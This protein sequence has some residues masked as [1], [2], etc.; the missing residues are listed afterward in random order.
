MSIIAHEEN[1]KG[2]TLSR[3]FIDALQLF[4]KS[5]NAQA[6]KP[7]IYWPHESGKKR[8][9]LEWAVALLKDAAT[10]PPDSYVPIMPVDELSIACIERVEGNVSNIPVRR[11]HLGTID[12][13]F[14]DA[15]LDTDLAMYV[16]SVRR[17][18]EDRRWGVAVI[19]RMA[20][21]YKAEYVSKSVR[22]RGN[23]LRPVQLACQNVVIGLAA[24]R[25]DPTFDGLRVPVYLTCE[26]PHVATHEANRA[27]AA[28]IL[29]DAFQNGGTMEIRFGDHR[30]P[31]HIP[32]GLARF[33][34][35]V[36]VPL[37]SDDPKCITP[38]E[39]RKLFTAVTLMPDDLR[40]RLDGLIDRGVIS[41][42]RACYVLMAGVWTAIE[43][44]YV[45]ATSARIDSITRG[46][47]P[48]D[49]RGA[50]Q[51]ELETCR[52]A[53]ML[54]TLHRYLA[55][56]DSAGADGVRVFEDQSANV[57]WNVNDDH[58]AVG[59]V[60]ERP[61]TVPWQ[62]IEHQSAADTRV[63]RMICVP[64]GL[65]TTIDFA[66][67]HSL[68]ERFPDTAIALLVPADMATLVPSSIPTMLC[69]E[70]LGE[71]DTGIERRLA[72]LRVGR[73]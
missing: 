71:L 40:L 34:R 72:T 20:R 35:T 65:P 61:F 69:P 3:R 57:S 62:S 5:E 25:H 64:R 27:M 17:E 68:K 1:L 46:G 70:R 19:D 14:Q 44:D 13:R 53:A 41:P 37:G 48:F 4:Y 49:R 31:S 42:E 60:S 29:C 33:S 55:N 21:K 23:V 67:T 54:G 8:N 30:A 32:P 38:A 52:A 22:P 9:S 10:A 47:A 66:L 73:L 58:G 12:E 45:L 43:F 51:A 28:L 16:G 18:L 50:R 59:I 39:A 63:E 2:P 6:L 24:I 15:L 36:D 11:W 7:Y 56:T 26:V